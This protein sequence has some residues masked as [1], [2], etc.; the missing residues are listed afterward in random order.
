MTQ[1]LNALQLTDLSKSFAQGPQSILVLDQIDYCFK[2]GRSYAIIGRSGAGKSTLLHLLAGLESPSQGTITFGNLD[3]S[4]ALPDDRIDFLNR[5]IGILFQVPH[6]IDELSVIE[7]VMI[8]GL[9]NQHNYDNA[10]QRAL[11]L[12]NDVGLLQRADQRPRS[13]SCGEQQRVAVARALFCQ[14][15][16]IVADEPTAHLDTQTGHNLMKLLVNY[17]Q[18]HNCGLIVASHD[19]AVFDML[20]VTLEL[21]RGSL[22]ERSLNVQ[23]EKQHGVEYHG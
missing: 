2:M 18:K 15:S 9:I 12:L 7:N 21:V 23:P 16:F 19:A 5:H 20:D 13:L 4:S 1:L 11:L 6:L 3:L 10:Q 14:P 17:Q 8:K 22:I